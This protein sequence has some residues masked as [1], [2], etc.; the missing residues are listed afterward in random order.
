MRHHPPRKCKPRSTGHD[1]IMVSS[2]GNSETSNEDPR[3]PETN[4]YAVLMRAP[5]H[6]DRAF[7]L[8]FGCHSPRK[9][10]VDPHD[11]QRPLSLSGARLRSGEGFTG[12]VSVTG[13]CNTV[14]LVVME[15]GY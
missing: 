10:L 2:I 7:S 5:G 3:S 8:D 14:F 13:I 9:C 6:P 1:F 11:C 15:K 4:L 12:G